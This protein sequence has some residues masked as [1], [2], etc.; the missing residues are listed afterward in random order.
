V[1]V[2]GSADLGPVE[3]RASAGEATRPDSH[4][5]AAAAD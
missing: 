2:N 5:A 1:E 4:R 3:A